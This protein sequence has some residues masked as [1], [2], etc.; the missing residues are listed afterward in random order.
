MVDKYGTGN[1][2]Y[3]YDDTN[4]LVNKF[5]I[6]DPKV[7]EEAEKEFT[8]LAAMEMAFREP[9]YDFDYFRGIHRTLFGDLYDWAG[10]IRSIDISKG[11]T[12]FCSCN[13]IEKEANKLFDNLAKENHLSDFEGQQF[14]EK[15]AEYYCDINVL[16]PFREGNGRAQRILFE[17]ICINNGYNLNL[18]GVTVPEWVNANISGYNCD[19]EEME[20]IIERCLEKVDL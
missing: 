6:T 2:P 12:R 3:T 20:I 15:L 16:H 19:Y 7:L 5:G 1:D 11:S 14:V 13:F 17:H 4:V 9:P 8:S 18:S 10:E